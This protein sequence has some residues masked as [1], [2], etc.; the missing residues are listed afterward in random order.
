MRYDGVFASKD[1]IR[2]FVS[3][4]ESPTLKTIGYFEFI[5]NHLK[6]LETIVLKV[7][8]M[9]T[10]RINQFLYDISYTIVTGRSAR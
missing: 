8:E 6:E 9:V 5:D 7:N 3:V 2:P 10:L 4:S 1:A